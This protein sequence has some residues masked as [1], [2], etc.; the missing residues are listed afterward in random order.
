MRLPQRAQPARQRVLPVQL[1]ERQPP[2]VVGRGAFGA[3]LLVAMVEVLRE[4]LDDLGL[5]RGAEPQR[6][7]PGT[8]IAA[9]VRRIRDGPRSVVRMDQAWSTPVMSRMAGTK[10]FQVLRW[11]ASTRRPS[12]VSR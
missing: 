3:Q 10:V 6:R 1:L 12:A 2:R 8:Q 5:A 4:L 7:Q 9:P 11:L